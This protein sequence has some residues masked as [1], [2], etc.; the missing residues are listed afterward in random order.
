MAT[1][2][3]CQIT[4]ELLQIFSANSLP[5]I[6]KEVWYNASNKSFCRICSSYAGKSSQNVNI[7][8]LYI[9]IWRTFHFQGFGS[10]LCFL[11]QFSPADICW[12]CHKW[13]RGV[14]GV[15]VVGP[16]ISILT[17]Y[18][19]SSLFKIRPSDKMDPYKHTLLLFN[20]LSTLLVQVDFKH[21]IIINPKQICLLP[22]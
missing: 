9:W 11:I 7:A 8:Q 10:S 15:I 3:Q 13:L 22:W 12:L 6:C 5:K 2:R 4:A 14:Y 16:P 17:I 18:S 21:A 20:L 19:V 1:F